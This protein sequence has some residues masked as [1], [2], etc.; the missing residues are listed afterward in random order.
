M[1]TLECLVLLF[2][3]GFVFI[4]ALPWTRIIATTISV[5]GLLVGLYMG[6]TFDKSIAGFQS[7]SAYGVLPNYN[8]ALTFGVDGLSMVFLLLTLF[9][10]PVSFLAA[11]NASKL[12]LIYVYSMELLLILTF[13]TL[14]LFFFFVFFESL[15][16][17]M[18]LLV[19]IW[20]A[21]ERKIKAAY[22]FFLY[23]LFGSLFMLF[24]LLY[25]YD[26]V[27]TTDYVTLL[28][29]TLSPKEQKI[30]WCCFFLAF[31]VKMPLFPLHI[32][33]PEAHVEA[34]T[35]G[36]ML[37]ASLLLKLGGYA[38]L[39]FSLALLPEASIYFSPIVTTCGLLGVIYASLSTLRQIDMKRVIAY[40]SI[41]HMNLV[42][43]GLFSGTQEGIEGA[44]YLMLGH[45]LISTALF[46]C[47]GVLYDRHHSRLIRYYGGLVTAMPLYI[48]VLLLF[49]F[50]NMSFP[51][52]PNFLGELLLLAGLAK[53]SLAT[54]LFAA[55]GIVFSAVY[56][57][58]T[59]NRLAFGTLRTNY[60]KYYHDLTRRE[61][62]IFITLFIPTVLFGLSTD[63][64]IEFIQLPVRT[65]F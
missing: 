15:L 10:F 26:V 33:L 39:R 49:S 64:L 24:G 17:P 55:T 14:D 9:I 2:V 41:A 45:G 60:I 31:A 56:S 54:T 44:I 36:S 30:V 38:F 7:I 11:W 4:L 23:T 58:W 22:Y 37:L 48:A 35:V 28:H 47:V 57:V 8:L 62:I 59:L 61:V 27:G 34:P 40:S 50:A 25:L 43:L 13:S 18:F 21:R 29:A 46:F 51:G 42:V 1:T 5:V 52:T 16:I 63:Y 3:V 65:W 12:F 6:Y 53:H 19:G 32:W 20:G